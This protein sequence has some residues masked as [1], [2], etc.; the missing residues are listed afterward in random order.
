MNQRMCGCVIRFVSRLAAFATDHVTAR[1][2]W[3]NE[4]PLAPRRLSTFG[5]PAPFRCCS[6]LRA[7]KPGNSQQIGV[8]SIIKGR[9]QSMKC[10][11]YI[12]SRAFL[13]NLA[14]S[15]AEAPIGTIWSSSPW[16]ISVGTSKGCVSDLSPKQVC[17]SN[18]GHTP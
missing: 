8:H 17:I 4:R 7:L 13:T 14:E 15:R 5:H 11:R 1:S 16:I 3:P 9:A 18:Q 6:V 10:T 12:S 2:S